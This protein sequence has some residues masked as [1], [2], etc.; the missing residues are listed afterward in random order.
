VKLASDWKNTA[1]GCDKPS[2]MQWNNTSWWRRSK[3]AHRFF[4]FHALAF[5]I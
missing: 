5:I 2:A 4:E 3:K 1:L